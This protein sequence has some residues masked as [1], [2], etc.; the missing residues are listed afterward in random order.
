MTSLKP[1]IVVGDVHGDLNQLMYPLVDFLTHE[2]DYKKLIYLGDYIDRGESNLY[3]YGVIRFIMSMPKY[4]DKIIFLSGNHEQYPTAIY[5]YFN[6]NTRTKKFNSTFAY[7]S[8]NNINFDIV[9]YDTDLNIVFSHSPLS[10]PLADVLAMNKNKRN[11]D[12]N[13]KNTFTDDKENS[14]MEYKNIHGHIHRLSSGGIIDNF[15]NGEGK[16]ISIDGD[17]S[18]GIQLVI[19][20]MSDKRN[21]RKLTSRVKY[22][23]ISGDG[24][25]Y[26]LINKDI[27]YYNTDKQE[28][29]Y[30]ILKFEQL[31]NAIKNTNNYV[32]NKISTFKLDD[33]INVF[34][35]EFFKRFHTKPT[36]N[37]II[38]LIRKNY[39]S[40]V[41]AK[42]GVFIYFNDVPVDVYNSFGLFNDESNNEIGK[43]FFVRI[44]GLSSEWLNNYMVGYKR[45]PLSASAS[46]AL[47]DSASSRG[48]GDTISAAVDDVDDYGITNGGGVIDEA[49][50][51]TDYD[52]NDYNINYNTNDYSN[53]SNETVNNSSKHNDSKGYSISTSTLIRL[54]ISLTSLII[55]VSIIAVYLTR[56]YMKL[57]KNKRLLYYSEVSI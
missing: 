13:I 52:Y 37:N 5:D 30:N 44:L 33:M 22:L 23:I 17:S 19:N 12:E 15:F 54:F 29:N 55:I 20:F 6:D 10:R 41:N 21:K 2:D 56:R 47:S 40:C 8:I 28:I 24:M 34:N 7:N 18:Y 31:K 50:N 51:I 46:S 49:Y 1:L 43:L 25:N 57:L 36:K 9:H 38:E 27:D 48:D 32:S 26:Q 16:M 4:Q 39:V 42:E 3:I 53:G 14:K 45:K 11:E 35:K